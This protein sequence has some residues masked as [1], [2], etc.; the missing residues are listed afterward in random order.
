MR[1]DKYVTEKNNHLTRTTVQRLISEGK[2]LVNGERMKPSYQM[3]ESDIV[4][5]EGCRVGFPYLPIKETNIIAE[6]I[7]LDILY[8]DDDILIINKAK[9]MVVHPGNG[10]KEGTLANAVMAICSHG[11]S[12]VG[13]RY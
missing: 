1:L 4:E 2:V 12:K 11:L 9:G 5:I 13:R 7:P 8:E 3:M 10:N 6:D